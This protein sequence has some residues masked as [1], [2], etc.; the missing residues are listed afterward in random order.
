[1]RYRIY[2]AI[3]ESD[4][5]F[6]QLVEEPAGE[7]WDFRIRIGKLPENVKKN[8]ADHPGPSG[9]GEGFY[10]LNTPG[11]P[12]AVLG[13]R[14]IVTEQNDEEALEKMK[15]YLLG[16]GLAFLFM[17]RGQM[18]V[19]CSAVARQE[20]CILISGF[21]GAG[22]S[23]LAGAF[24]EQGW[25]LVADDVAMVGL[26]E[27]G[28][29]TA[30]AFPVRKLCR[31]AAIRK[32]Y[33]PEDLIYVDEDKDKFALKCPETFARGIKRVRAMFVLR[34]QESEDVTVEEV[35]GQEKIATFTENLFL[36]VIFRKESMDPEIFFQC[37][38]L[39]ERIPVYRLC[40]PLGISDSTKELMQT[41]TETLSLL[42]RE[43]SVK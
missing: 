18:A 37:L 4:V 26:R 17:A 12:F 16:Y 32:G 34:P 33:E 10:W 22:K 15:T 27:N 38:K 9:R 42:L 5:S 28:A 14:E 35:T 2:D 36:H 7:T 23:T 30:P 21:S 41:V 3:L 29:V 11:G 40:R 43:K 20:D 31:D 25:K 1:M 24:L 8:L 13:D 6:W 39:M 19:H